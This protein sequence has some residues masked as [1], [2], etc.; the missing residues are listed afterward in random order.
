MS[1]KSNRSL[2]AELGD[3]LAVIDQLDER[4]QATLLKLI[5]E[6]RDRQHHDIKQ[7]MDGALGFIP[8][9]LRRP[10]RA[11]FRHL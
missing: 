8:A 11:L 4:Q 10:I 6:A 9:L 5:L 7:A 2:R 1:T 3:D